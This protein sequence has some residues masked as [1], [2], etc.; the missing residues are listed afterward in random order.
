[1]VVLFSP[2][3]TASLLLKPP[4]IYS[5]SIFSACNQIDNTSFLC[6]TNH[7]LKSPMKLLVHHHH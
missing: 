3:L 4:R 2:Q 7:L 5:A 6:F 1:M